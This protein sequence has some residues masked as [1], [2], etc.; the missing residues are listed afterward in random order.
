MRFFGAGNRPWSYLEDQNGIT[1]SRAARAVALAGVVGY[2]AFYLTWTLR[3]H[4]NFAT[5]AFDLGIHDQAAWLLSRGHSPF[6]TI[7]GNQYFGDHLSWIMFGIV[8]FYWLFPTAKVLLV[9]QTLALGLAAVPAFL[10]ARDRLRSEWLASGI[11]WAYLLNPYLAWINLEQF[12]PDVF[13]VPLVFLAFWFALKGRWRGFLVAVVLMMLVKEDAP[14]LVIGLGVLVAVFYDRRVGVASAA[15]A[16]FWLVVN[17]RFLLP[18]LSGTGS[19]AG[20]VSHH[21]SRI[22]FGG[23]GGFIRTTVTRP[24][25]VVAQLFGPG[26]PLYYL[27]VFAPMAFLPLRAPAVLA[28][29]ALPLVANGLS[30]FL[31]QYSI[32]SHYG[33]LVVPSLLVASIL[34]IAH[35]FP[36]L[37]RLLVVLMIV[38][39]ILCTWLWG[40]APGSRDQGYWPT[41]EPGFVEATR[42]AMELIPP[43]AVVSADYH[44]VTHLDH[45]VEIYEFPNPFLVTN[46]G[47]GSLTGQSLPDRAARVRYVLVFRDMEARSL[48]ALNKLMASGEFRITY[49]QNGVVLL[50][51]SEQKAAP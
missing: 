28:A 32:Q 48:G 39:A 44:V 16:A 21:G 40:P 45:R 11:V 29:V 49:E 36:R 1:A 38:A 12:H 23:L 17:F 6:I 46:W 51:R 13:E 27:Q 19:L 33:T 7:S 42:Q 37:R 25:R 3:N 2:L 14:L 5:Y 24:W 18:V 43:D 22:P 34:G 41:P 9:T 35:T 47:D 26:R 30:T 8:P 15:L 31:Y 50:E 20:Y 4:D 10:I